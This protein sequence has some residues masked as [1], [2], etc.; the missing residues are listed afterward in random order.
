MNT[1]R[2]WKSIFAKLACT[3]TKTATVTSIKKWSIAGANIARK[4]K[5]DMEFKV[6]ASSSKGNCY[7]LSD[8]HTK[9]MI[10]CGIPEAKIKEGLRWGLSDIEAC[11]LTHSHMDHAKA[12]TAIMKAGIDLYC[13][14][15]CASALKLTGMVLP[16][17]RLK[18]IAHKQNVQIGSFS[19]TAFTAM[20]D[21]PEPL[22]FTFASTWGAERL[23]FATDT[24]YIPFRFANLTH[25]A[26]ECN[27][28][29]EIIEDLVDKG[30]LPKEM[31]A[32]ILRSHMG[33]D[34]LLEML[35]QNDLS[36]MKEIWL[37][38]L[39]DSNSNADKFRREVQQET[40]IPTYIA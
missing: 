15:G 27:Y 2:Q 36:K 11:F 3:R 40:G 37:L 20:H 35:H 31:K 13:S 6:L 7:T 24:Y 22:M 16:A 34:T 14:E 17:H 8:G 21:A 10:E 1:A 4:R 26:L 39:S 28:D 19:V 38:H 9:I 30:I 18:R 12:T 29:K 23:L 32:R 25:A 5:V 33:K